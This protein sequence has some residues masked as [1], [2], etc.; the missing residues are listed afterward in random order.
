MNSSKWC[1]SFFVGYI[2]HIVLIVSIKITDKKKAYFM[3]ND[4]A[5]TIDIH[6]D[7]TSVT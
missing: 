6:L 4:F 2:N 7:G 3:V 5:M 1:V